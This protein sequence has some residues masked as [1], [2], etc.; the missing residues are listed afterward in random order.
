MGLPTAMQ[1]MMHLCTYMWRG[2]Y[3]AG[4]WHFWR[5]D[6][7]TACNIDIGD[8]ASTLR[9]SKRETHSS[10]EC[11]G[12]NAQGD[13]VFVFFSAPYHLFVWSMCVQQQQQQQQ[14]QQT[15]ITTNN[16]NNKWS[17]ICPVAGDSS[18]ARLEHWQRAD[19]SQQAEQ[20][21]VRKLWGCESVKQWKF[22]D[23]EVVLFGKA[24]FL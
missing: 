24:C 6:L 5:L 10:V 8:W 18:D 15:T 19:Q 23:I 3:V 22:C 17:T 11:R 7:P 21:Q 20:Q 1:Q 9:K 13:G 2:W 16:N 14:Q 4:S 12:C